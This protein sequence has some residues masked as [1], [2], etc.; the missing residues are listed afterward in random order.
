[1]TKKKK[2]RNLNLKL[3]NEIAKLIDID[4]NDLQ[5][6]ISKNIYIDIDEKISYQVFKC[7]YLNLIRLFRGL[8]KAL[9]II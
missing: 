5:F 6:K 1:M 8:K 4:I 7:F 9:D 2:Y 3:D